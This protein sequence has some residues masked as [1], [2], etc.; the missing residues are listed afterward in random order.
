MKSIHV[1]DLGRIREIVAVLVRYGFG[2]VFGLLTRE[3]DL[4]EAEAVPSTAPYARRARQALMELGPTFVKLGQVLSL[5]PDILPRE[6]LIELQK[7]QQEVDPMGEADVRAVLA[8]ELTAPF[9]EVFTSFDFTPLG[10]ASIAQ[11]HAATLTTGQQV[12]VKLQRRG[13][14]PVI[15]SDLHILYTL[16]QLLE[17]RV[18]IPGIYTPT[19]IIQEFDAAIHRELDFL[20]ERDATRRMA[21]VLAETDVIVPEVYPRWSTRRVMMMQRI[22]GQPLA[23]VADT[24]D[25]ESR[26]R[27]AH[28]LMDATYRQV[29]DAGFFHGDPHPG[30]LF[31]TPQGVLVYLDFGITG[32]LTASM[33]DTILAT[34]T[35]MVFRD[36]DTLAMTIYRAGATSE[37]IDL[38]EFRT[39]LER[40]ML[41]YYGATLDDLA[42]RDTLVEV[43]EMATRFKINLP[44][45]FAILA[46][47]LTLVEGNLRRLLPD[48]DIVAEVRPYADRLMR[49][50]FAPERLAH[51]LGSLLLR[52]QAQARE[53]PTQAS[54]ALLDLEAGRLT[55]L[56]RDPEADALRHTLQLAGMRISLAVVAG[57]AAI[58]AAI[59]FADPLLTTGSYSLR[60]WLG[61]GWLAVSGAALFGLMTQAVFG[62]GG[63]LRPLR[64]LL[65]RTWRFF[66]AARED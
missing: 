20:Q 63:P 60:A 42:Q 51:E 41:E 33:Q 22:D 50:R 29:F 10:A 49:R 44:A 64:R 11:V 26:R 52:V 24:L 43:V 28:Q 2:Q 40:K 48:V 23:H 34:F 3:L 9:D 58:S 37:R 55:V 31:V 38:R 45:E 18:S 35:A 6:L 4:P 56:A 30:N 1:Q 17:G 16:A 61:F 8:E 15:R 54:Q 19:A 14:E 25:L 7:L 27:L 36:P 21:E 66:S 62:A 39:A 46:R 53:L 12:A 32:R 59:V 47:A 57:T 13:I 65:W 5:R